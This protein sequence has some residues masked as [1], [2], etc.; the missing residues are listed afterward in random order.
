MALGFRGQ[1]SVN[2]FDDSS[3]LPLLPVTTKRQMS[4]I[5]RNPILPIGFSS[6]SEKREKTTVNVS[7]A[8]SLKNA[9]DESQG[10]D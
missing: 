7:L 8:L 10:W 5:G 9:C 3:P 4:T 2:T 1:S 6:L